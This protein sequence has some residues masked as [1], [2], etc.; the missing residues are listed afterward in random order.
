MKKAV[1]GAVIFLT[2]VLLFSTQVNGSSGGYGSAGF[3][4]FID[5]ID[6]RPPEMP[7]HEVSIYTYELNEYEQELLMKIGVHEAG[8]IDEEGIAHVMQVV[9]NRCDDERFPDTVSEVIFQKNPRQFTTAK[10]L[11]RV[12]ITE[13]A[14]NALESVM[15]GEYTDNEALYFESLK[16]RAWARIHKYLFSYGGHDF[17][18]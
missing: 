9:L 3:C 13:A 7:V 10:Q 11:A 1:L 16:G 5:E 6:C 12:K 17:Y 15:L 8:E 2:G 4:K 14:E 18:K